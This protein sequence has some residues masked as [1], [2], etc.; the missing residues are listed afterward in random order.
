MG[1]FIAG[2]ASGVS[3]ELGSGIGSGDA[4]DGLELTAGCVVDDSNTTGPE[5]YGMS[6]FI[7]EVTLDS[8]TQSVPFCEY[9]A[10]PQAGEYPLDIQGGGMSWSTDMNDLDM[11]PFRGTFRAGEPISFGSPGDPAF[12]TWDQGICSDAECDGNFG[13]EIIVSDS[14]FAPTS[15]SEQM[16][17]GSES[18][19]HGMGHGLVLQGDPVP[20]ALEQRPFIVEL[21][22]NYCLAPDAGSCTLDGG[23]QPGYDNAGSNVSIAVV[24][25]P[26]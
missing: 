4:P 1:D 13:A 6:A 5:R 24:M 10:N 17:V 18:V 25:F 11:M 8:E 23:P 16:P 19:G 12:A 20:A 9:L 2:D 3:C 21:Y 15:L 14:L 26:E 7:V 22:I